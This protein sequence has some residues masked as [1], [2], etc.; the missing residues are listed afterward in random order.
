MQRV[1][2]GPPEVVAPS[3]ALEEA[4][5]LARP[6]TVR[7]EAR[8]AGPFGR[9]PLGVGSG[10]YVDAEGL[11]LTAYHV[12]EGARGAGCPLGYWA[13]SPNGTER[14]LELV[15]FDAYFDLAVLRAE[16]DR[17]VPYIPLADDAPRP[18]TQV[19]A[20]GNSRGEFLQPRAGRVTR[21]GVEA[22][23][24]DFADG[25]VE[26]TAALAPGDSG[27]PVVDASGRAVGVV[28][29]ISF[30][31]DALNSD[32]YVPP[33]LRGLSLPS[34]FASYAVPV[35]ENSDLVAAV[36]AGEQ[37]D[38]P[39]IGF[40]WQQGFDYDPRRSDADFGRRPG[41]IV[42]RVEPGG[43]A[44][45]AGLRSFSEEPVYDGD[46]ELVRVEREADVI[47][48]VDGQATP[49]FYAL[50]E[51]IRRKEIGET[52][53]LTV[54]RGKA[55]LKLDLELGAKRDVFAGN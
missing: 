50:L 19:V 27:G 53:T 24:A 30:T 35:A 29:F 52:V 39:V 22:N 7:I 49:G 44:D 40:S 17:E 38:V 1:A 48:A 23:R 41:A 34:D 9:S 46:G 25:T 3:G 45:Q 55:T 20:I 43:P 47:V 42:V 26:L 31:P 4:Y 14:P 10:F 12:V 6:A 15:G 2:Q 54:Q 21:V 11:L 13:V 36:L 16:V 18:G 37:R 32:A 33:F 28:S 8:C 51:V 5:Q